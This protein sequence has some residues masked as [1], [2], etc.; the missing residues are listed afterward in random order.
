MYVVVCHAVPLRLVERI[1][2]FGGGVVARAVQY[3][4]VVV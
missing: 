2:A 4:G 1:A 3:G